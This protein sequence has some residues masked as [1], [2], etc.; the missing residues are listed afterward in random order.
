MAM[1]VNHME[2][3]GSMLANGMIGLIILVITRLDLYA[4]KLKMFLG[5]KRLNK[6]IPLSHH[7]LK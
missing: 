3:Y 4:V 7:D 1:L 2:L 6:H 5:M